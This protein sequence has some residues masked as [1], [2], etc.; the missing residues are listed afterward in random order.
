MIKRYKMKQLPVEAVQWIGV[1]R[2]EVKDFCQS[3]AIFIRDAELYIRAEDRKLYVA[4][5]D[6]IVRQS[7]GSFC[8][9]DEHVFNNT[10]EEV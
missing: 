8:P 4:P 2:Q 3:R 5:G 9:L 10:Y 7:D 6:Y 1:N